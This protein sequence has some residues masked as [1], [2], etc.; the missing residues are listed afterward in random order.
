MIPATTAP[1]HEPLDLGLDAA[2]EEFRADVCAWLTRAMEGE[3]IAPH[4]DPADRTGV[5]EAF[6]RFLL[7]EA[8]ARGWLGVAVPSAVGGGGRPASWAAAFAYEAAWHHAPLVDTGVVLASAPVAAYGSARQRGELL[9]AMLEGTETWCCAYTEHASGNDLFAGIEASAQQDADGTWRITG[10][11]ALVTGAAKADRCLTVAH[12]PGGL[13]MFVVALRAEGVAIRRVPTIAGYMLDEI[14]FDAAEGELLGEVGAGRRQV[15]RAVRAEHGGL[16]QLGWAHRVMA[17][18]TACLVEAGAGAAGVDLVIGDRLGD[19]WTRLLAGRGT[20]VA[21]VHAI[22]AARP[23]PVAAMLAKIR[24]TE[25]VRDLAREAASLTRYSA[26]AASALAALPGHELASW[27][28]R[29]EAEAVM[30]LDGPISVGANDLHREAVA[31][32][33]LGER[34]FG[35]V[36]LGNGDDDGPTAV[37]AAAAGRALAIAVG[38]AK[39]RTAYGTTMARLPVVRRRIADMYG[40]LEAARR[41]AAQ[42]GTPGVGQD[43]VLAAAAHVGQACRQIVEDAV[44]LCGGYGYLAE[45]GLGDLLQEVRSFERSGEEAHSA[46]RRLASQVLSEAHRGGTVERRTAEVAG[47]GR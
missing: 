47:S 41:L 2:A 9:P 26:S 17:D 28:A 29:F 35:E 25:L 3:H 39:S 36:V 32:F 42:A 5:D 30:R 22:E 19:M 23:D 38:R 40:D 20:A 6:E 21:P 45:S 15:A 34:P 10:A 11:K 31:S 8:G 33:V 46:R 1:R 16:F 24:L 27:E 7:R 12:T 44:E 43:V 4:R 14:E 18:L 13:S 37:A